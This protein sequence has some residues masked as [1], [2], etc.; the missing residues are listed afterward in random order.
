MLRGHV[1]FMWHVLR[2]HGTL[3][4]WSFS[5]V[6]REDSGLLSD[7]KRY[8]QM[9]PTMEQKEADERQSI[10]QIKTQQ[11]QVWWVW[12]S[13]LCVWSSAGVVGVV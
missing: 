11:K 6:D 2:G 8:Q 3:Y 5:A 12:S 4:Q 10:E 1:T 13:A 7:N 9:V